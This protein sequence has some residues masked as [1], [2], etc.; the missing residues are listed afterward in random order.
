MPVIDCKIVD[1]SEEGAQ[2]TPINGRP[3]PEKFM[4]QHEAARIVG[5]AH[6]VWRNGNVV[7]VKLF[8]R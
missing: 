2:V 4:L 3:L 5:E 8:K 6:V 7:G 1:I